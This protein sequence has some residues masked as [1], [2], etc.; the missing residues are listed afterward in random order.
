MADIGISPANTEVLVNGLQY[1]LQNQASMITGA[2]GG[3]SRCGS[4]RV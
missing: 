1:G 3:P 2:Q 4:W